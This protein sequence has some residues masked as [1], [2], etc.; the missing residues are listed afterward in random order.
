MSVPT[1]RERIQVLA[2]F[3]V[4]MALGSPVFAVLVWSASLLPDHAQHAAGIVA[5][6]IGSAVV[7]CGGLGGLLVLDRLTYGA[8]TAPAP[9]SAQK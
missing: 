9:E 6:V 1:V 4:G 8:W 3:L 7:M 2:Y 5:R